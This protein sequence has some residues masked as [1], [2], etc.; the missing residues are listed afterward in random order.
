MK[1]PFILKN[2]TTINF[3]KKI[4]HISRKI[5]KYQIIEATQ[6]VFH[7]LVGSLCRDFYKKNKK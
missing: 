4:I 3:S 1:K 7:Y 2:T 5:P 6:K